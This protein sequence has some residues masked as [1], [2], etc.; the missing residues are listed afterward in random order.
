MRAAV[1]EREPRIG[2]PVDNTQAYVV[3]GAGAVVAVGVEGEIW[4]GGEGLARGYFGRAA[5]TAERFIP[6][7]LS[8]VAGGRLYR[9]GDVGRY[10]ASGELEYVGRADQ[11]VKVRG[12]RIE[13]GEIEAVLKHH[14]AVAE[15]AVVVRAAR[16]GEPE[17]VGYLVWQGGATGDIGELRRYLRE[18]VPG[19]MVPAQLVVL[20][21]LPQTPNGKLDR[22]ALPAPPLPGA[23]ATEVTQARARTPVEEVLR[24]IWCEVLGVDQLSVEANF[25]DLGGHSLLATQV[26]SRAEK[27]FGVRLELRQ[28]FEQ[29]TVRGLGHE[30]E[31]RQQERHRVQGTEREAVELKRRERVASEAVPL[32]YGQ[33]R[34]WF[35]DRLVPNSPVYNVPR[36]VRLRG[37]LAVPALHAALNEI[38][39]RHATL[40]TRFA[41]S[42]SEPRQVVAAPRP[43]SLPLVDLSGLPAPVRAEM[44]DGLLVG[45]ARRPFDLTGGPLLRLLLLRLSA[46]EHVLCLTLHHIVSDAWSFAL[47]GQELTQLYRAFAVGARSGLAELELQYTDYAHWQR[48]WVAGGGLAGQ[49]DYWREQLA[50]A[51][52]AL[53]LPTDYARPPVQTF[54][55]ARQ[56]LR[57]SGRL[58][59]QLRR[60]CR[61]AQVTLFMLLLA[62]FKTLLWRYTGRGELTVGTVV[63]NRRQRELEEL[64]GFFVNTLPLRTEVGA[65]RQSFLEFL[66]QVRGVTLGAYEHQEVPFE[67]LVE[68]LQPERS[69]SHMPLFQTALVLQNAPGGEVRLNEVRVEEVEVETGTAKFDLLV[70][71]LEAESELVLWLEYSTDL[72]GE[73]TIRRLGKQLEQL[74][75]SIVAAPAQ[76]LAELRLLTA[77][78]QQQLL[79]EWNDTSRRYPHQRSLAELFAAQVH[80]RPTRWR[81]STLS[82]ISVSG[83]GATQLTNWRSICVG[84]VSAPNKSG[85]VCAALTG[86]GGGDAGDLESGSSL[87]AAGSAVSE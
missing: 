21:E 12:Y 6:D 65:G 67:W 4:L 53:T 77:G 32:S 34:L 66:W 41:D 57:L 24:E 3:D 81:S 45:E 26:M 83:V 40:R 43:L 37:P 75:E 68:E 60:V 49:L 10:R 7:A 13:L 52:G 16:S 58:Q 82:S 27:V 54:R 86:D 22:R 79:V 84:A 42:A 23:A 61:E 47:L 38:A 11:Q 70:Q 36:A 20:A 19:Y 48:E 28:L 39:R 62:A 46:E 14:P 80:A 15:A 73:A 1:P 35:L 76:P 8:G 25:F 51:V 72:F 85:T 30:I 87:R 2:R 56:R 9:T 18:Q 5:Q 69:L 31:R 50:G 78:E 74:L 64:I 44:A 17:I 29:P 33:Q 55:G 63:A 71:A 59:E